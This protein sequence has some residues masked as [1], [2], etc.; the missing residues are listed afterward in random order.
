M[1]KKVLASVLAFLGIAA[2]TK[3]EDGKSIL[4]D[5]QKANL[6]KHFGEAFTNKFVTDLAAHEADGSGGAADPNAL[7]LA[8]AQSDL[9]ALQVKFDALH[10]M[11]AA[12]KAEKEKLT[13]QIANLQSTIVTL[14][15]ESET[16]PIAKKPGA[17]TGGSVDHSIAL[18]G[19]TQKPWMKIEGRPWNQRAAAALGAEI[20]ASSSIDYSSLTSDLGAYYRTRKDDTIKSFVRKLPSLEAYFPLESGY[21]DQTVLVNLFLSEFSQAFQDTYT[22]KGGYELQPEI[23]KMYDVK[24]DHKF[25]ELKTL[26]KQW[27]GYLNREG[28]DAMKW[29]FIEYILAE[30]S[31][32]LHNER[33]NRRMNGVYKAPTT[34]VAGSA[35]NAAN[36]LRKF[37]KDK[38]AA[39]QI[40]EFELGEW[41][42]SNIVEYIFEGSM[43]IP[44]DIRDTGELICYISADAKIYYDKNFES[45][46]GANSNYTGPM[47]KVK[48]IKSIKTIGLPFMG[49]SKRVVWTIDGNI[50]F[51]EDKPGEM[52]KFNFEQEDRSLKVWADWREGTAAIL[53][54]KKFASVS[55]QDYEHQ[56]IW[57]NDVDEPSTY[58][59]SV[60]ADDTTPSVSVHTS[61]KTGINTAATA[62][63][64]IDDLAVGQTCILKCGSDNAYNS[65]IAKA[66]NFAAMSAAWTPDID[67]TITLYKRAANDIIDLARTTA[68][69]DALVIAADDTT[70]DVSGGTSFITSANTVATAITDLVNPTVGATYTIY[71]GSDTNS[72]TIADAGNFD[73]TAAMTLGLGD[74]IKLYCRADNDYVEIERNA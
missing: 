12:E 65:T 69:T 29:S 52:Y 16:E 10:A 23:L 50:R 72:S 57:C 53:V 3:G 56:M 13:G 39:F 41:T 2:L 21:Q 62:I 9:A 5:D 73:L 60:D 1:F 54:G 70:P 24:L 28:A 63:T 15:Q 17:G 55:E 44:Q 30:T 40:K 14:S 11:T 27:I 26:E 66:G 35:I 61:L 19:E 32:K 64:D 31:K 47:E 38:I 45:L 59:I 18:F 58:F 43:L 4:T 46:Y 49:V 37:L 71:G 51:F 67:D 68:S 74:W 8:Q 48:F 7:A 22:A 42:P 34:G 25:T 20:V 6:T 33:E 36:G